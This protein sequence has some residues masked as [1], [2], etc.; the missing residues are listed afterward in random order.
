VQTSDAVMNRSFELAEQMREDEE[1]VA[2]LVAA[3]EGKRVSLV[4]AKQ[5]IANDLPAGEPASAMT[6]RAV[7][8]IDRAVESVSD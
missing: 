5:Q 7:S 2:E 8:L 3:A 6:Q 4:M 1:A